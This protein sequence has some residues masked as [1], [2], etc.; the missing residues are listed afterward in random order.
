MRSQYFKNE[1]ARTVPFDNST[2]GYIAD[3]VQDAIEETLV[4]AGSSRYPMLFGYNGNA[5]TNRWLEMFQSNPSNQSGFVVAEPA[6]VKA[7]SVSAKTA[8]TAQVTFYINAV[9]TDILTVT[10]SRTAYESGLD[11]SLDP[12]DEVSA[13]V[14]SGS[15]SDPIFVVTAKTSS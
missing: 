3:N 10:A 6:T 15:L 5:S 14:T 4:N 13:Q 1:I 8:A 7:M 11:W 9:A 12:G 2:N